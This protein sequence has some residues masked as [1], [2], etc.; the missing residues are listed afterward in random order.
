MG[1]DNK[2]DE[3]T[4]EIKE[5]LKSGKKVILTQEITG[6]KMK[7]VPVDDEKKLEQLLNIMAPPFGVGIYEKRKNEDGRI[8]YEMIKEIYFNPSHASS[9]SCNGHASQLYH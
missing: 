9:S 5:A 1:L 7:V 6:R 4:K 2:L 8:Y 3:V